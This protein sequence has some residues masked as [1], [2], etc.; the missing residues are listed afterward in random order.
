V[1]ARKIVN[2]EVGKQ[3]TGKSDEGKNVAVMKTRTINTRSV[4]VS[5]TEEKNDHSGLFFS[6]KRTYSCM[7]YV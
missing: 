6:N 3:N 4:I 2:S 5:F 7:V 1:Q